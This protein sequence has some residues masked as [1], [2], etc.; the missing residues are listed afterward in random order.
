MEGL[1]QSLKA[2]YS[3]LD[4]QWNNQ[5]S[6]ARKSYRFVLFDNKAGGDSFIRERYIYEKDAFSEATTMQTEKIVPEVSLL[7]VPVSQ[8]FANIDQRK[9]ESDKAKRQSSYEQGQVDANFTSTSRQENKVAMPRRKRITEAY[10]PKDFT[11]LVGSEKTNRFALK[12]LK[13]WDFKVF[14]KKLPPKPV[15]DSPSKE[16]IFGI[17][18]KPKFPMDFLNQFENLSLVKE[19]DI[20]ELNSKLLLL[21][22]TSGT[23]KTT[24][25]TVI[26]KKCG[27]HPFKVV[28]GDL[29]IVVKR[30]ECRP[31]DNID[32]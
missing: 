1:V 4:L 7:K 20:T 23:G 3:I 28:P 22:G 15:Q 26:A 5:A 12:W 27:Y 25:A 21:S 9:L 6:T 17:K 32:P 2:N 8:M 14:K 10:L 13:A 16:D 29:D 11:D 18:K 24:L 30:N 19:K 31:S